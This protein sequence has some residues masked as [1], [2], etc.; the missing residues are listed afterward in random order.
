MSRALHLL[1]SLG[2]I[3]GTGV[4]VFCIC[5]CIVEY[6]AEITFVSMLPFLFLNNAFLLFNFAS[7]QVIPIPCSIKKR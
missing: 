3:A 4:N 6:G 2:V 5:H 7:L 1:K